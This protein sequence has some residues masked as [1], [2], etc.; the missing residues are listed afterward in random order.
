MSDNDHGGVPYRLDDWRGELDPRAAAELFATLA[1]RLGASGSVLDVGTGSGY[2][3]TALR[4]HGVPVVAVDVVDWRASDVDIPFAFGDA[5]VLPV[6]DGSCDGVHMARMLA[7]VADWRR[8]LAELVRVLRPGGTLCLSLGGWLAK[9]PLR[10]FERAVDDEALRRGVRRPEA[11]AD[12]NDATDVDVELAELGLPEPE[13]VEVVGTLVR[14]P[15]EIVADVVGRHDRWEAGQDL[16]VLYDAGGAV[17]S[18]ATRDVDAA[19]NQQEH[20]PYR[21]YRRPAA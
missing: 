5:C 2:V 8:A 1:D 18:S 15:R 19:L 10:D 16:S 12:Y 14:S 20:I 9:G 13:V 3:A 4:H 21:V 11:S 7:H 17:L 6:A